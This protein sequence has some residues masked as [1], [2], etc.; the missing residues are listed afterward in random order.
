MEAQWPFRLVPAFLSAAM[1]TGA[2]PYEAG[3]SAVRR[4]MRSVLIPAGLVERIR[5]NAAERTGRVCFSG[6]IE[7]RYCDI[8]V[9]RW[10]AL[11][12]GEAVPS[13]DGE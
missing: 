11:T 2:W 7:P 1:I 8:A 3:G 10:E 9:A 5:H 4:K 12:G 13:G 6:E